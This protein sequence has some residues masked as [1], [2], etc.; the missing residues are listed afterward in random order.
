MREEVELLFSKVALKP[1]INNFKRV[2]SQNKD[3]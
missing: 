3:E 2:A 1:V